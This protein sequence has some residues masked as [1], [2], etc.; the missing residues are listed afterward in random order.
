MAVG[1]IAAL[2]S[3]PGCMAAYGQLKGDP[4]LTD[5]FLN[6]DAL[7]DYNYYY[8]GRANV[9]Y[10]VIGIDPQYEFQ[11]RVWHRIDSRED[12]VAKVAN[13]RSWNR[14]WSQGAEIVDASGNRIGIWFS[15]YRHTTVKVGPENKVAV[16][17]PYTPNRKISMDVPP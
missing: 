15:Y 16:Y 12:V 17:S 7:P 4:A 9:P 13:I 5:V 14:E 3:I 8:N 11:D 6:K 1:L 2:I 10:A